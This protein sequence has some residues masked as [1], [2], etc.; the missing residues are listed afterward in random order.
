[1]AAAEFTGALQKFVDWFKKAKKRPNLTKLATSQMPS[2]RGRKGGVGPRRKKKRPNATSRIPFSISD[3]E[4]SMDEGVS[5]PGTSGCQQPFPSSDSDDFDANNAYLGTLPTSA[6]NS[7]RNSQPAHGIITQSLTLPSGASSYG[8]IHSLP[9]Y[10][11]AQSLPPPLIPC[12]S[13]Y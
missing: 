2:G 7:N 10:G 3:S 12:P 1:M 11:A 8:T 13:L 9:S 4:E 5:L 6:T